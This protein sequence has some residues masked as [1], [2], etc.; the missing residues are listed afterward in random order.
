MEIVFI[1]DD[2]LIGARPFIRSVLPEIAAWQK[3][4]GFPFIFA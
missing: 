1:V 2:N 4:N 3:R